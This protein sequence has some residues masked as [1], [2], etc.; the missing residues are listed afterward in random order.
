MLAPLPHQT[1]AAVK[2]FHRQAEADPTNPEMAMEVHRIFWKT[3]GAG[4]PACPLCNSVE[5]ER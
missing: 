3:E 5:A 4:W 2:A 1:V